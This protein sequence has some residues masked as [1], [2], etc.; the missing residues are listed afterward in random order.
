[1]IEEMG[2]GRP[3]GKVDNAISFLEECSVSGLG[4]VGILLGSWELG[5][6]KTY[7]NHLR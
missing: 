2:L 1:M 5:K 3:T 7:P 6:M 4:E